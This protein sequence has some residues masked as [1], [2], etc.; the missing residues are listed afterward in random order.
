[1]TV[2]PLLQNTALGPITFIAPLPTSPVDVETAEPILRD[3]S[4][5]SVGNKQS[6]CPLM[7]GHKRK[8]SGGTGTAKKFGKRRHCTLTCKLLPTPLPQ[9]TRRVCAADIEPCIPLRVFV[10]STQQQI[11][12]GPREYFSVSLCLCFNG[13]SKWT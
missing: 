12:I 6:L 10:R 4:I 5:V 8:K 3:T 13:H 11:K 9:R 7:W 1:M 2:A